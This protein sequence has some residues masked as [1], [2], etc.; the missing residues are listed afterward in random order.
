MPTKPVVWVSD[1]LKGL[2]DRAL[3]LPE[4]RAKDYERLTPMQEK[5]GRGET[6]VGEEVPSMALGHYADHVRLPRPPHLFTV[7]GLLVVSDAFRAACEGFDLGTGGFSPMALYWGDGTTRMEGEWFF[8]NLGCRKNVF[9]P[10]GSTRGFIPL[11]GAA[12]GKFQVFIP[13]DNDLAVSPGALDGCDLWV[14]E[15]VVGGL[16][17]SAPLMASLKAAKVTRTLS[18]RKCRVMGA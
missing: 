2:V 6:L 10:E 7:N 12:E 1:C 8:L 16:F 14:D 4:F 5:H 15:R 3:V 13:K 17:F 9:M 11:E 18:A